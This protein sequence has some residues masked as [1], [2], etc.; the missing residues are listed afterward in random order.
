MDTSVIISHPRLTSSPE[1]DF[2]LCCPTYSCPTDSEDAS[3]DY[4]DPSQEDSQ[5]A[6]QDD[7]EDSNDASQEDSQDDHRRPGDNKEA[8]P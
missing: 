3:Q 5:D 4:Q 8:R 2:P 6:S 7:D 1:L